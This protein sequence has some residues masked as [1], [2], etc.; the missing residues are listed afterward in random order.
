MNVMVGVVNYIYRIYHISIYQKLIYT[1]LLR[2]IH[3]ETVTWSEGLP[4]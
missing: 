1:D 2:W 4:V 3:E